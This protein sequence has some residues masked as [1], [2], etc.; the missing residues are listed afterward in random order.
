MD[1]YDAELWNGVSDHTLYREN[2]EVLAVVEVNKTA[3]DV[4]L[5]E[6]QLTH[7][8]TEIEKHQSFSLFGF[9]VNGLDIH[10]V[11]VGHA[12]CQVVPTNTLTVLPQ[13]DMDHV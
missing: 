12:R 10:F 8:L 11:D 6:A 5:A 4:R 3:G 13:E 7:D 2:G 9:L 1:C